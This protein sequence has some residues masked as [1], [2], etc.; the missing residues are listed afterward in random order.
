MRAKL[1][2]LITAG[3]L[4]GTFSVA[5]ARGNDGAEH[6]KEH[7]FAQ[8]RNATTPYHRVSNALADGYTA[9][10]IPQSV[11]GTATAGLGLPGDPTCFDN[12]VGGMGVHYVKGIDGIVD[13]THPEA[14]VYS[15]GENGRLN[16]VAVENIVP[17]SLVDP[18]NMPTLFGQMF[19]HHPYLPVFI[20]HVWVWRHNPSGSFADWNPRVGACPATTP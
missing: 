9:F 1:I 13:P 12:H 17:D 10:N 15:V 14:L 6:G 2:A 8:L 3:S 19:H 7:Q 20:L 4:V 16:L 5:Q 11:G 18:A